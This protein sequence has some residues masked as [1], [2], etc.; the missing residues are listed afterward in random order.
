MSTAAVPAGSASERSATRPRLDARIRVQ[1]DAFALDVTVSVP[2]GQTVALVGPNGAGKSTALRALSGL[3]PLDGGHIDVDGVRWDDPNTSCF[4]DPEHRAIGYVF[5]DLRLFPHLDARANVAFGLRTR[6]IARAAADASAQTWLE[7]VGLADFAHRRPAELSGGQAQRVALARALAPAPDL[8]LLDEPLAA[9]DPATRHEMRALLRRELTEFEGVAV[10]V[11][12]DPVDTALLADEAL[13][14]E[15][16]AC[17]QRAEPANL[18]AHPGTPWVARWADTNLFIGTLQAA[19][20][21]VEVGDD[22][23]LLLSE[24]PQG[25]G[26]TH[27]C[28]VA[29]APSAVVLHR[30]VPSGSARNVWMGVLDG[31]EPAAHRIRARVGGALPIVAEL[32]P[33]GLAALDLRV[34]DPVWVAVKATELTAYPA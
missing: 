1:H 4:V 24:S 28:A 21:R 8:L 20:L 10:L 11:T 3:R 16:G 22:A 15:D 12:H 26:L 25:V 33:A 2:P 18:L 32:T 13:V 34:G 30:D 23:T 6:G 9:L 17:T 7:R 31:I 14:L 27:R 29:V 19:P 5:Q